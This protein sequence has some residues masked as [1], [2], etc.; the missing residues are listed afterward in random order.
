M[1][2]K[3]PTQAACLFANEPQNT[4]GAAVH[5]D[6]FVAEERRRILGRQR[7]LTRVQSTRG[8]FT[9]NDLYLP[10]PQLSHKSWKAPK[11]GAYSLYRLSDAE[12]VSGRSS[13]VSSDELIQFIPR[14][15]RALNQI[16]C[17][18]AMNCQKHIRSTYP[19]RYDMK[20][21]QSR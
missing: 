15:L 20:A 11:L 4:S 16:D 14:H 17:E 2:S 5:A 10:E 12:A 6:V 19:G 18:R 7:Y 1:K 9:T 8:L 21:D 13:R 3:R